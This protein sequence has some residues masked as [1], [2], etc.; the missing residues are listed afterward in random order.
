MVAAVAASVLPTMEPEQMH[1]AEPGLIANGSC[2]DAHGSPIGGQNG[3]Q[4]GRAL[5]ADQPPKSAKRKAVEALLQSRF[6]SAAARPLLK[7]SIRNVAGHS[8][9]SP[10]QNN[11]GHQL[12]MAGVASAPQQNGQQNGRDAHE[13]SQ[14]AHKRPRSL[15]STDETEMQND[16]AEGRAAEDAS[17]IGCVLV[18]ACQA[19]RQ[20]C[21]RMPLP[22]ST[23]V[24]KICADGA[25]PDD[26]PSPDGDLKSACAET[27]LQEDISPQPETQSGQA[28]LWTS[29][30]VAVP[31][32]DWVALLADVAQKQQEC[33]KNPKPTLGRGLLAPSRTSGSHPAMMEIGPVQ[34]LLPYLNLVL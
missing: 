13:H 24:S 18:A 16:S 11:Q 19:G 31:H 7:H 9:C 34:V 29:F 30:E 8:D 27:D 26:I 1:A 23:P 6:S 5:P 2:L 21:A 3:R 33:V 12:H 32:L 15:C 28:P 20:C 4:N 22:L 14:N 17:P 25:L 10:E